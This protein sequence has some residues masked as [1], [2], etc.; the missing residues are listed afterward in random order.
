[1]ERQLR[2]ELM[3]FLA[4]ERLRGHGARSQRRANALRSSQLA[5]RAK[6]KSEK[7]AALC[8]NGALGAWSGSFAFEG[9]IVQAP[10]DCGAT[11]HGSYAKRTRYLSPELPFGASCNSEEQQALCTNGT[12]GSW[13]GAFLYDVC[14]VGPAADC[15]GVPHG[16]SEQRTRYEVTSVPFGE[17]CPKE[18]QTHT[19][20]NGFWSDWS[21]T[22]T[23]ESCEVA[24]PAWCDSGH[25]HGYI[26]SYTAYA[27]YSVVFGE[28]CLS[29]VRTRVCNDG[30]WSTWTGSYEAF[31]CKVQEC[32]VGT[33]Q[34]RSC[35]LNNR[36]TQTRSCLTG[37][38]WNPN[39]NACVDPDVC[40]DNAYVEPTPCN[41]GF[42]WE[43]RTCVKGQY[44]LSGTCGS[45]SGT[46]VDPCNENKT[47]QS[48]SSA[49]YE[50][51]ACYGGF[52]DDAPRCRFTSPFAF[53]CGDFH[54]P[55]YCTSTFNCSWTWK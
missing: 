20:D 27:E 16:K 42:G 47:S 41:G 21:G 17:T 23:Y 43:A 44:Q 30:V 46:F 4:S 6:C 10:A 11:P 24:Q 36:G 8:T 39:W 22:Y 25:P 52:F 50:G 18:E 45:C 53:H 26:D 13:S 34:S 55:K 54:E 32:A 5:L 33:T 40:K 3:L 29:E 15:D 38:S 28:S 51:L 19:C 9:C 37:G 12:L 49:R 7:Q 48:C 35:G 31:S 1:M 14:Q 2:A